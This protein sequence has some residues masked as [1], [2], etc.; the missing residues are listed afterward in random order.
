MKGVATHYGFL[1][2]A[3]VGQ[4]FLLA[5]GYV[6]VDLGVEPVDAVDI[7]VDELNGGKLFGGDEPGHPG[8]GEF[9]E[10]AGVHVFSLG[11]RCCAGLVECYAKGEDSP[12][13]KEGSCVKTPR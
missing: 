3:C 9:R 1:G 13:G 10:D 12:R 2:E 8:T 6:G 4:G 11:G 5:D 7:G